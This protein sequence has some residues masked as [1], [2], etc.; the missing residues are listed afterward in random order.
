MKCFFTL[1]LFLLF[2]NLQLVVGQSVDQQ[3]REKIAM[4]RFADELENSSAASGILW[5]RIAITIILFGVLGMFNE[6]KDKK[7]G[8]L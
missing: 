8:N 1:I 4:S 2:F 6:A 7:N 5:D 3:E